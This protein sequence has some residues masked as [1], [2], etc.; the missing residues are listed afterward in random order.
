M[1]T[2]EP[3]LAMVIPT[4]ENINSINATV[5][6]FT[7][8]TMDEFTTV[9]LPKTNDTVKG[10]LRGPMGPC[11]MENLSMDNEKDMA[12]I[13]LPMVD[14]MMA[15]G[16]MDDTTGLGLVHG[17]VRY[18]YITTTTTRSSLLVVVAAV[19]IRVCTMK[20]MTNSL[21]HFAFFL[22]SCLYYRRT[23]IQG[24]MEKW[25]GAWPWI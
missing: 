18:F 6:V 21:S 25:H 20:G 17:K 8:G 9:T 12:N 2:E 16:R 15:R 11:T 5:A 4:K 13:P 23:T 10:S 22:L 3:A 7:N 19:R 24:R 1:A 14:S